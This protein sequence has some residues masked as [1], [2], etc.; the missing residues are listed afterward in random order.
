MNIDNPNADRA[1]TPERGFTLVEI[2]IVIVIL[3]ILAT[4]T[5]FAVRGTTERASDNACLSERT[6]IETAYDAYL[7]QED[8]SELPADG[9][10]DDRFERSLVSVGIL[11]SVSSNWELDG[12]GNLTEQAGGICI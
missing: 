8:A 5:V 11:R 6:S 12:D 2:L 10:G 9:V 7:V 3:G 4:V 1:S